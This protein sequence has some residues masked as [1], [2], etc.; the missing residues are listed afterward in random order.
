MNKTNWNE[1]YNKT[2][3]AII[4]YVKDNPDEYE[5]IKEVKFELITELS[6][7]L[8]NQSIISF[9]LHSRGSEDGTDYWTQAEYYSENIG[10]TI[11]FDYD[12][13]DCFDSVEDY[14]DMLAKTEADIQ[15]FERKLSIK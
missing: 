13:P 11:I 5:G 7:E 10:K 12:Y 15:D 1:V 4:K 3:K 2:N 8:E 9:G 6:Y 14:A